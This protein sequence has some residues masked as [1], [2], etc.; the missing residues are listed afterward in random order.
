[1]LLSFWVTIGVWHHFTRAC[2]IIIDTCTIKKNTFTERVRSS[3]SEGCFPSKQFYL[4]TSYKMQGKYLDFTV[5]FNTNWHKYCFFYFNLSLFMPYDKVQK[6]VTNYAETSWE[7]YNKAFPRYQTTVKQHI[8]V[9]N[10]QWNK[11]ITVKY[12]LSNH[13]QMFSEFLL[14]WMVHVSSC[15]NMKH[16][17]FYTEKKL[18]L[19]RGCGCLIVNVLLTFHIILS[20]KTS[21]LYRSFFSTIYNTKQCKTFSTNMLRIVT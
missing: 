10:L 17:L 14:V 7:N 19:C 21:F 4:H 15:T 6:K 18:W 8:K 3:H 2:M 1:M 9:F 11:R 12:M 16:F 13:D 20:L 5:S